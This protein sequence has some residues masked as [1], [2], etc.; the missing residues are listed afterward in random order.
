MPQFMK[1]EIKV[2][3]HVYHH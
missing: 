3:D 2:Y 1:F